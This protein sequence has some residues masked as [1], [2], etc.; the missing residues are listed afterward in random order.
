MVC[1]RTHDGRPSTI[2]P[3]HEP[4]FTDNPEHLADGKGVPEQP[5]HARPG[6]PPAQHGDDDARGEPDED[7][8]GHHGAHLGPAPEEE[9]DG[10]V[11][12]DVQRSETKIP[13]TEP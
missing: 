12:E 11:D 13:A 3:Y 2:S 4:E 6:P 7:R 10:Q 5:L 1:Q 8:I 9:G